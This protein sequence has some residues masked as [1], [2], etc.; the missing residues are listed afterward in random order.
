MSDEDDQLP[1]IWTRQGDALVAVTAVERRIGGWTSI[2]SPH[3][4]QALARLVSAPSGSRSGSV[5]IRTFTMRDVDLAWWDAA[6]RKGQDGYSYGTLWG[7]KGKFVKNVQIKEVS[8][9]ATAGA[10]VVKAPPIDPAMLAIAAAMHEVQ[11]TLERI[12]AKV[13]QIIDTVQWLEERRQRKQEAELLAAVATLTSVARRCFASGTVD[14]EDLF[15]IGHLEQILGTVHREICTELNHL[16][17]VISYT[18]VDGAKK[19]RRIDPGRVAGL[20]ELDVFALNGLKAYH[21]LMLL[22]K[23]SAGRLTAAEMESSR[24]ELHRL[25]S[26]TEAAVSSLAAVD[27]KMRDRSLWTYMLTVGIPAGRAA[28]R[29]LRQEANGRRKEA[30]KKAVKRA[31]KLAVLDASLEQLQVVLPRSTAPLQ[32]LSAEQAG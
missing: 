7:P 18:D 8:P 27:T 29:R 2:A 26:T 28:D 1:I 4:H 22:S 9:P 25:L 21:Q 24:E 31:K 15:R 13:D 19:A 6:Q 30:Q 3:L 32:L 16:A 23:A 12:E 11:Q 10:G 14:P 17:K 20:V 5:Q